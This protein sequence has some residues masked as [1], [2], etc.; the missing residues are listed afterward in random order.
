MLALLYISKINYVSRNTL[1]SLERTSRNIFAKF[2][3]INERQPQNL[4][5]SNEPSATMFDQPYH[6]VRNLVFLVIPTIV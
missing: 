3:G 5:I 2:A 1:Y 6:E 4:Q